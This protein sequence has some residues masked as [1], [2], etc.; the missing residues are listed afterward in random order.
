MEARQGARKRPHVQKLLAVSVLVCPPARCPQAATTIEVP[1]LSGQSEAK[2]IANPHSLSP[3]QPLEF[4]SPGF[5]SPHSCQAVI[6][7]HSQ[8]NHSRQ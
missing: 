5:S 4:R 6:A 8:Q 3:K 2:T 7:S 1:S